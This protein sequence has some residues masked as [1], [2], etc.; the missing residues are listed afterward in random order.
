M[1]VM[2]PCKVF[3]APRNNINTVANFPDPNFRSAVEEF[4]GVSHDAPFTAAQA[5]AKTGTLDCSSRNISYTTG[6]SFFTNIS[7]LNCES[8]QLT[9]LNLSGNE[10]LRALICST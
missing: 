10:A 6:I 1:F 5:V 4:I 9:Q 8:N 3:H 7:V 2:Q